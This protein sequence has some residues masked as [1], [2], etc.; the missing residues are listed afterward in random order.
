MGNWRYVVGTFQVKIPVSR[1]DTLLRDEENTLAIMKWRLGQIATTNRW[2]PVLERCS[3]TCPRASTAWAATRPRSSPL[4]TASRCATARAAST[5]SPAASARWCSTASATSKASSCAIAASA[6]PSGPASRPSGSRA[7]GVSAAP[8]AHR[9]CRRGGRPGD[10]ADRRDLLLI[11]ST[12]TTT[13]SP[14]RRRLSARGSPPRRPPRRPPVPQPSSSATSEVR[15]PGYRK[16]LQRR[17]GGD[18]GSARIRRRDTERAKP[19][20][21]DRRRQA[22][23]AAITAARCHIRRSP[24]SSSHVSDAP[25][26]RAARCSI[27]RRCLAGAGY[28]NE[29]AWR[30][31][32]WLR[33]RW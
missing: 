19:R 29:C 7:A 3:A 33:L 21:D 10:P 4:R 15:S 11:T 23:S 18:P 27:P 30:A 12:A 20:A 14:R 9:V 6:A 1:G 25:Y 32:P 17:R 31:R 22:L 2:H 8:P 13:R 26:M 24:A 5:A 28:A 16:G